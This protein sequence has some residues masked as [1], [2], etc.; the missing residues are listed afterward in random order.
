MV[1]KDVHSSFAFGKN[2]RHGTHWKGGFNLVHSPFGPKCVLFLK[3]EVG[4]K[5]KGQ[6][7]TNNGGENFQPHFVSLLSYQQQLNVNPK[8]VHNH[9]TSDLPALCIQACCVPLS[10]RKH[11][12][13]ENCS[14]MSH[15]TSAPKNSTN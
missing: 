5:K 2:L 6:T 14:K 13:F 3:I 15:L 11:T 7:A 8:I 4:Q 9:L 1:Q 10:K 12:V